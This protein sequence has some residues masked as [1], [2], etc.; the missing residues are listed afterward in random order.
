MVMMMTMKTMRMI[1]MSMIMM[2]KMSTMSTVTMMMVMMIIMSMIV[3]MMMMTLTMPTGSDTESGFYIGRGMERPVVDHF[4]IFF[5]G[6]GATMN[7]TIFIKLRIIMIM[8]MIKLPKNTVLLSLY[9]KHC[10]R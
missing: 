1:I 9:Y 7:M 2:M 8:M 5:F 3:G 6:L 4:R 10:Q